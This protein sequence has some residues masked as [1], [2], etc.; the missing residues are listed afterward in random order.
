MTT[1]VQLCEYYY[2]VI[3]TIK[4]DLGATEVFL[5]DQRLFAGPT[6]ICIEP[7]RK[8]N[9]RSRA[10]SSRSVDR[11]YRIYFLVYC[12]YVDDYHK[13]RTKS[14]ELAEKL[15]IAINERPRCGGLVYDVWID[16]VESG[17]ITRESNKVVAANRLTV[18]LKNQELLPTTVE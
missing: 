5:G 11:E 13:N 1:L 6:T 3:N 7:D 12:S 8:T 16:T 15:E 17:Y 9:I 14:D 4:A 10:A 18:V 2:S